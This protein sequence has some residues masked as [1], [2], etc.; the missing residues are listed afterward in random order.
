MSG[1]MN[2]ITALKC[3][4][5]SYWTTMKPTGQKTIVNENVVYT[6]PE[7]STYNIT[8]DQQGRRDQG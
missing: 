8:Q 5:Q 2:E 3:S 1:R 7:K 6:V 4:S